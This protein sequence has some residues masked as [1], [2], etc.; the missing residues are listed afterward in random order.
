M[1]YTTVKYLTTDLPDMIL[2][3]LVCRSGKKLSVCSFTFFCLVNIYFH[4]LV[5][6]CTCKAAAFVFAKQL[7]LFWAKINVQVPLGCVISMDGV[8]Y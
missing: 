3:G 7:L 5:T 4:L 8:N 6:L 1:L 2:N